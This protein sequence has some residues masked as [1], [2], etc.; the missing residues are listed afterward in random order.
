MRKVLRDNN[1]ATEFISKGWEFHNRGRTMSGETHLGKFLGQALRSGDYNSSESMSSLREFA[2][3]RES[4]IMLFL[5]SY[6]TLVCVLDIL[7]GDR[8][9][10]KDKF[11]QTTTKHNGIFRYGM[12]LYRSKIGK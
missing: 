9:E 6:D 2:K 3:A 10:T 4:H 8:W 11:S 12:S 5:H 1:E 7:T